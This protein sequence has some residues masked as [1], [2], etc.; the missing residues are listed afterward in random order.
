MKGSRAVVGIFGY[1]DDTIKAIKGAKESNL[2]FKVYSPFGCHEI[3]HACDNQRSPVRIVNILAAT[4]GCCF[5]FALPI[6]CSMDYPLRVSAKAIASVPAYVVIGYECTILFGG[7]AT[8]LA[9]LHFCKLP[10]IFRKIGY[11]PRFSYDKF[12]VVIGCEPSQVE[13]M[14]AQLLRSGAEEVRVEDGI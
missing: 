4:F 7:V 12:G 14:K 5:G 9:I 1:L 3:D 2:D 6:L 10:N 8:L 11:D 13:E